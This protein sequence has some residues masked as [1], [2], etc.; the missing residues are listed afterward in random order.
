MPIYEYQCPQC[1]HVFEEW[2]K[3]SEAHREEKC[4]E[5]GT[6]S[7]RLISHTSFV[8]KGGG[9][10]VT[11]YGYRKGV[12]DDGSASQGGAGSSADRKPAAD[13]AKKSAV[14]STAASTPGTA[15]IK[16]TKGPAHAQA[17]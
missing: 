4:P 3:L 16:E 9:W 15:S 8:L 6:L 11:D 1:G 7:P 14:E 2:V 5:C 12:K 13:T 17:S 10:Y